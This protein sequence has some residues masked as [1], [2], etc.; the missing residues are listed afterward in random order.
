VVGIAGCHQNS[1]ELLIGIL[2]EKLTPIEAEE[3]ARTPARSGSKND[4]MARGK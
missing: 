1:I 2:C 4:A 3:A